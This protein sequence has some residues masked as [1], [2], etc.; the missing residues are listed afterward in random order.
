M[1]MIIWPSLIFLFIFLRCSYIFE[2]RT[3]FCKRLWDKEG[4][5]LEDEGEENEDDSEDENEDE[6][7]MSNSL[8][9]LIS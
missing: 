3:K 6:D 8:S 4:E 5:N 1:H 7:D 9:P 2:I